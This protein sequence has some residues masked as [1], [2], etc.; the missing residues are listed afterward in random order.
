VRADHRL[1]S[2][3]RLGNRHQS[4]SSAS[5]LRQ[6]GRGRRRFRALPATWPGSHPLASRRRGKRLRPLPATAVSSPGSA[7]L[8]KVRVADR[9]E[10][11]ELADEAIILD[12]T[13][14]EAGRWEARTPKAG[15]GAGAPAKCR[16]TK[17]VRRSR[18]Q[19]FQV[20]ASPAHARNSGTFAEHGRRC[21]DAV[22]GHR[23]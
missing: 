9:P 23:E 5:S 11:G 22:Y 8:C 21:E 16:P 2:Q 7:R 6:C 12:L 13:D 19:S 18:G 17:G 20:R 14:G 3:R 15:E 10:K 4:G 1:H